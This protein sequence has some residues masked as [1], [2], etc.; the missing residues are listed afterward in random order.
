MSRLQSSRG[1]R[2]FLSKGWMDRSRDSRF[3]GFFLLFCLL[4]FNLLDVLC[5]YYS[6]ANRS[7]DL[8]VKTVL[9][10][11]YFVLRF[12]FHL[13]ALLLCFYAYE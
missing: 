10:R 4:L 6:W 12:F 2:P 11:P 13:Q 3:Q 8:E 5:A 7:R 1:G 9:R